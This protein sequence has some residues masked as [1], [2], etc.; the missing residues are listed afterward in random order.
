MSRIL[1]VLIAVLAFAGG[2]LWFAGSS[3][4]RGA[5][6]AEP[7]ASTPDRVLDQ[8]HLAP[9]WGVVRVEADDFETR[10]VPDA[11]GW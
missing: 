5:G 9:L 6:T 1:L 4:E 2:V 8:V 11:N 10:V 3:V 7:A